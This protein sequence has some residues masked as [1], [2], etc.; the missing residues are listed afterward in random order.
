MYFSQSPATLGVVMTTGAGK[1]RPAAQ[2]SEQALPQL[3]ET[4]LA[5]VMARNPLPEI[6]AAL[7]AGIEKQDAG[8]LCSVL[9]LD[10]DGV[11]L[12]TAAAPGLPRQYCEAINGARIGPS[13]GSCG[14][15]A[16]RKELVAVSDIA[17]DP[18]WSD[19][20]HLALPHGLRAC[21]STPILVPGGAVAGTFAI[22]Y[23]EP[24]APDAQHLQIIAHATHL[25]GIAI[26][27]DRAQMQL[28]TVEDRYRTLVERLPAIT[29]VAEL[30]ADGPWRYVSPQIESMLGYSPQEWL[31]DPMSWMNCI[32]AEDREIA[33]AAEKRFQE[34]HELFYA[35]YRMFARDGRVLWFRDEAVLLQETENHGLLM[36]GVLYD[37]SAHKRLE[38]ELRHSQKM[39]AVGQL[40]GG[41][42]HDFNNLLM[43]IQ[44]HNEHL[45]ERLK[46]ADSAQ[47]DIV[48]IGRAVTRAAALTR[49]LL[50]FSRKQI[51]H[52]K[53]LDLNA[54]VAQVTK[55]LDR[56]IGHNIELSVRQAPS[57]G[58][59]KADP[60]QIEQVIL[61]LAVNAR[62]AMPQGGSLF[63]ETRN[64]IVK[65]GDFQTR[66]DVPSGNYVLLSVRD[67][68]VGMDSETQSRIFE[69]FFTTKEPGKGTGLGLATVYGVVKQMDGAIRVSSAPARGATFEIYLPRV[70]D[71]QAPDSLPE[72]KNAIEAA[73]RGSETILLAEDQDGIRD[74]VREFLQ[75]KGYT[76][77][78]ATDGEDALRIANEHKIP[79]DLLLTDLV[80][81]NVGGRD[82]AHHLRQLHPR[83]KVLFM[84]GYAE[85]AISGGQDGGAPVLQK[86]FLLDALAR[87]IR[88]LL[89]GGDADLT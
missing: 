59:V 67:N 61:N 43:L 30:G 76:V 84:S 45:R 21:W 52:V 46:P 85:P 56:L 79:V 37:I 65:E 23:R 27:H 89:D 66:D 63:L 64:A 22:Y 17:T 35:E 3:D 6:L 80:M 82:L 1:A 87:K 2:S 60:G 47:E 58:R 81:P 8:L 54:I 77:L 25:A 4:I 10:A 50:A 13:V 75:R 44:A 49:Q 70:D 7:C 16:Y 53:V 51:L 71:L 14:T 36:Q 19:Y 26:A 42:A 24:C 78:F 41:V 68:G 55:M 5:M 12:R 11:T 9:L 40:A 72:S 86:P 20:R 29:Y 69:P 34:T 83:M 73:P 18:L 74:L 62:D 39:E 48:E 15:A 88:E 38:E 31:A 32:H 28:R 57:L 33:L